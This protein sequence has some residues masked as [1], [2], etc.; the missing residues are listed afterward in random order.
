MAERTRGPASQLAPAV[1]WADYADGEWW[2]LTRGEDFTQ[3]A[4]L[5]A[6]AA[7]QWASKNGYRC[8]AY[9]GVAGISVRFTKVVIPDADQ[10]TGK[11]E[12]S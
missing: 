12:E 5:A 4:L 2:V 10:L 1:P 9:R 11:G 6:R 3:D 8:S 7:R